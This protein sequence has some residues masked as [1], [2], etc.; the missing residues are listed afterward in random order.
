MDRDQTPPRLDYAPVQERERV[1]WRNL[2]ALVLAVGGGGAAGVL[3]AN[4]GYGFC[5]AYIIFVF[6]CPLVPTLIAES[7]R[8]F[9][10]AVA[11]AALMAPLIPRLVESPPAEFWMWLMVPGMFVVA[12]CVGAGIGAAVSTGRRSAP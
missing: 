9:C 5:A 2:I 10:G 8:A 11:G 3:L 4:S 6:L 7:H 1:K 12:A